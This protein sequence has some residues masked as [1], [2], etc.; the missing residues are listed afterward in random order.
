MDVTW[1]DV[2][3]IASDVRGNKDGRR[4]RNGSEDIYD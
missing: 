2:A 3:D 1:G 4:E